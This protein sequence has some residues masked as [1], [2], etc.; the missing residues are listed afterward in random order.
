MERQIISKDSYTLTEIDQRDKLFEKI[1]TEQFELKIRIPPNQHLFIL[2][3]FGFDN[4]AIKLAD[5]LG[6]SNFDSNGLSKISDQPLYISRPDLKSFDNEPRLDQITSTVELP[7]E[8]IT[9]TKDIKSLINGIPKR[10]AVG[11]VLN[12]NSLTVN[13][14]KI[15]IDPPLNEPQ[16]SLSAYF[17]Y[18]S[19]PYLLVFD[20]EKQI[21][22]ELGTVLSGLDSANLQQTKLYQLGNKPIK[23]KIQERDPEIT[24]LDSLSLIYKDS[25]TN[26][27]KEVFYTADKLEKIDH[28]YFELHQGEFLEIDLGKILPSTASDIKLKIN[29]YYELI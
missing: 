16:F 7:N 25:Q 14:K 1:P 3:E 9:S 26:E 20:S 12:I 23:F 5:Y 27:L 22:K 18:G 6:Y 21:W 10:L 19:C 24:Y 8:F 17:A 29:G 4:R 28:E 2:T 15:K 11:S 13:G